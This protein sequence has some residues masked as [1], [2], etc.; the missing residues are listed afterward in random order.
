MK[1][2]DVKIPQ[3]DIPKIEMPSITMPSL[4]LHGFTDVITGI[5]APELDFIDLIEKNPDIAESIKRINRMR[6]MHNLAYEI[7][8]IEV[9]KKA[10]EKRLKNITLSR[11]IQ[12]GIIISIL[13]ITFCVIIPFTIVAFQNEFA[14]H[15][16]GVLIYLISTFT[17]S[18]WSMLGYLLWFFTK[19]N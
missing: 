7:S 13:I 11:E 1:F 6:D 3:L 16:I 8:I 18:M 10:Y 19:D 17:L 15:K 5:K 2:P 14:S 4:N 9:R 12:L